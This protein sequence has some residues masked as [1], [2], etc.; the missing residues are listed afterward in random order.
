M[1]FVL[2]LIYNYNGGSVKNKILIIVILLTSIFCLN[3]YVNVKADSGWDTDYD[4]GSSWDSSSDWDSDS[5]WD[6]SSNFDDDYSSES[7]SGGG[8]T[9]KECKKNSL[10]FTFSMLSIFG[11]FITI[12]IIYSFI[13]SSK[14]RKIEM[15]KTFICVIIILVSLFFSIFYML[16]V[17]PISLLLIPISLVLVFIINQDRKKQ[18]ISDIKYPQRYSSVSPIYN[19]EQISNDKA[20]SVISS[21]SIDEFNFKAYQIFYDTQIAW[22]EF[23][24]DK[25]KN[26]LSDEL[27]NSYEM[28]L[29]ALKIKNQKNIMKEFE[30]INT[31]LISLK[32][33]NNK[34]IAKVVM[35]VKFIDYIEDFKT[36]KILRG[37]DNNKV[38]N[39]YILTFVRSKE[40]KSVNKC[41]KCGADVRPHRPLSLN[42]FNL[43]NVIDIYDESVVSAA[44]IT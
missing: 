33:E 24:Y 36:H 39:T 44:D 18:K 35:E 28:D 41:P 6:S 17:G 38:D 7:G 22:M 37:N 5:D 19:Y 26:I 34:Y 23:D 30:L 42:I 8:C 9:T 16:K 15:I 4:S 14:S 12:I 3:N 1:T 11:L 32:E 31:K 2:I 13:K 29:E 10:I 20:N 40:E 27:Y 43:S 25:L 21:F